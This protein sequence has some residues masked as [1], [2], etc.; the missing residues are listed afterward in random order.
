VRSC[1]R[2]G[3]ASRCVGAAPRELVWLTLLSLGVGTGPVATLY[4]GKV[5]ID[6]T[7]TLMAN[8]EA[9]NPLRDLVSS[10]TLLWAVVAFLVVQVALD[11]VE[12][13][14][15]F[16]LGAFRDKLEGRVTYQLYDKVARFEDLAL[17]EY[18]RTPEHPP[19]RRAGH[20]KVLELGHDVVEPT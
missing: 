11:S 5:V 17:F 4:L 10:P 9:A 15:G 16:Q 1:R 19:A 12:T 3:E 8:G 2:S 13:L 20:A 6:E 7:T 18:P 14:Q